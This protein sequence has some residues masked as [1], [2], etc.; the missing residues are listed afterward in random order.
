MCKYFTGN[1][2]GYKVRTIKHEIITRQDNEQPDLDIETCCKITEPQ[3]NLIKQSNRNIKM[4]RYRGEDILTCNYVI[5]VIVKTSIHVVS[6]REQTQ[7]DETNIKKNAAIPLA[8]INATHVNKCH[9]CKTIYCECC[10]NDGACP[11]CGIL[12]LPNESTYKYLK[13]HRFDW[14]NDHNHIVVI[15]DHVHDK[16]GCCADNYVT[17]ACSNCSAV[18]C[19]TCYN[20]CPLFCY[21]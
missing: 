4:I 18:Y 13:N 5:N 17:E 15:N 7:I 16:Y 14:H 19:S 9:S 8:M 6:D 20:Y 21:D 10:Y 12:Q 11:D 2:Q 1:K 3:F